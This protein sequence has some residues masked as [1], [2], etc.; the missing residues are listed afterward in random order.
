MTVLTQLSVGAFATLWM[1]QLFGNTAHLSMAA[2]VSFLVAGLAL[3][4]ATLHL[5]RPIHAY[6][7]LKMWKRSWLS[8]EVLLFGCFSGVASLY[9]AILWFRLPG[10]LT[11]GALTSLFG[12]AG[13]IA[14]ACIYIVPARPAW[15]SKHTLAE[16]F[17]TSMI[18]G[19]LLAASTGAGER[20]WLIIA[21]ATAAGSQLLNRTV[22]FFW[23]TASESFELQASARL[24]ATQ[25]A[26]PFVGG[27]VLLVLAAMLLPFVSSAWYIPWASLAVALVAEILSRYVFFVSVVPK[28]MAASYLATGKAAA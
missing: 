13:V 16:F 1:L 15:N 22:K 3:N 9:A 6:R 12:A 17:L 7:A 24:L 27:S 23:L 28:N 25:L 8:R 26:R 5:G 21:A 18:L 2:V 10:S 11:L 4:A 20:R 19:P 14:S